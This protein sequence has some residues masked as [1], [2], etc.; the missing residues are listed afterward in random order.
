MLKMETELGVLFVAAAG[1]SGNAVN[2]YPQL[3]QDHLNGMIV[4]GSTDIEGNHASTSSNGPGVY[5]WAP[6]EDLLVPQ[7]NIL[8]GEAIWKGGKA[9]GTSFGAYLFSFLL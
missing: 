3:A 7:P 6:G 9:R 8:I 5:V 1:N 2:S 4:V